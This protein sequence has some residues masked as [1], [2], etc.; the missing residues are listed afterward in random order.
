MEA[1]IC[2]ETLMPL[3]QITLPSYNTIT[4]SHRIENGGQ[5]SPVDNVTWLRNNQ[6]GVQISLRARKFSRLQNRPNRPLDPPSIK[7]NEYRSK[8]AGTRG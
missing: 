1:A 2:L 7:F 5:V 6:S 8:L 4:L 3:C